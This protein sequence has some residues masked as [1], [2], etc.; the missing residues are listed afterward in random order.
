[1]LG[2]PSGCC[3]AA[4]ERR[5]QA[6]AAG[7]VP[8]IGHRRC[9]PRLR[10]ASRA[11]RTSPHRTLRGQRLSGAE[12]GRAMITPPPRAP[13]AP[14]ARAAFTAASLSSGFRPARTSAM[15]TAAATRRALA[16]LS[17]A[18][19]RG[20][21]M[22]AGR[23]APLRAGEVPRSPRHARASARRPGT[24]RHPR[25]AQACGAAPLARGRAPGTAPAHP[26]LARQRSY[27]P[28]AAASGRPGAGRAR[29]GEHENAHAVLR[30][31]PAAPAPLLQG[32]HCGRR[33]RPKLVL[34]R[35]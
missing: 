22:S 32:C 28:Y 8:G 4:R 20:G 18:R 34:E 2:A 3:A 24:R 7:T 23:P 21:A 17:P 31:R 12:R 26:A 27:A 5:R 16:A 33:A 6:H 15:P 9:A 1:M 10:R 11:Q 13:P 25:G 19:A 29:T 30:P 14:P 35:E